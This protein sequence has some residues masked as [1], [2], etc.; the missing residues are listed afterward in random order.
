VQSVLWIIVAPASIPEP[1]NLDV[2]TII[3]VV[4]FAEEL[5]ELIDKIEAQNAKEEESNLS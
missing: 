1:V 2:S 5:N 4:L 3:T